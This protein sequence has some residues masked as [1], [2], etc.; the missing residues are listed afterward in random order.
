MVSWSVEELGEKVASL[1]P[2][3]KNILLAKRLTLAL[4]RNTACAGFLSAAMSL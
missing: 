1:K 3:K 4:N 2:E